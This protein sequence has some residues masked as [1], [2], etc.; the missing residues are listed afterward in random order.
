MLIIYFH[1]LCIPYEKVDNFSKVFIKYLSMLPPAFLRPLRPP[2]SETSPWLRGGALQGS[3]NNPKIVPRLWQ[4]KL[5][6]VPIR[7]FIFL[8]HAT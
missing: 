4:T 8:Q 7:T 2:R 3:K 6:A 1:Y 5:A